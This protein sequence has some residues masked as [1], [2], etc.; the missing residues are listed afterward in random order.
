MSSRL[1]PRAAW[2]RAEK[3][4]WWDTGQG[5]Q[6]AVSTLKSWSSRGRLILG[7]GM[8][9]LLAHSRSPH[10]PH[11]DTHTPCQ[12]CRGSAELLGCGMKG[13]SVW[14]ER[15]A[16]LASPQRAPGEG[17]WEQEPQ[18]SYPPGR[19]W[20]PVGMDLRRPPSE[21]PPWI[22]DSLTGRHAGRWARALSEHASRAGFERKGL[23]APDPSRPSPPRGSRG[24]RGLHSPIS[25]LEKR[26]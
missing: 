22:R 2:W 4:A 8:A 15:P 6:A 7:A 19:K 25:I 11:L 18:G 14:A 21:A 17:L 13:L 10:R 1:P 5:C 26:H 23:Q 3:L 16:C 24:L 9:E 12:P 20:G